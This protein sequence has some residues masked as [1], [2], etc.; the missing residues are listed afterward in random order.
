M[1]SACF[2]GFSGHRPT[3][4]LVDT[5]DVQ[6]PG[7]GRTSQ[8][9][10]L[11]AGPRVP[12]ALP[13]GQEAPPPSS[14]PLR[15]LTLEINEEAAPGSSWKILEVSFDSLFPCSSPQAPSSCPLGSNSK[16][17]VTSLPVYAPSHCHVTSSP[18]C[19]LHTDCSLWGPT[20]SD[21]TNLG[22]LFSDQL[23]PLPL[24]C[25]LPPLS[26]TLRPGPA[27]AQPGCSA[28]RLPRPS[29]PRLS[30]L[31]PHHPVS[32]VPHVLQPAAA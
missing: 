31:L 17:N 26:H 27:L 23:S 25:L 6:P 13:R 10:R 20:S 2:A 5:Q 19:N 32:F 28:W 30:H 16:I 4:L 18:E 22:S 14:Q 21:P 7:A 11:L 24:L 1:E 15:A 3:L 29:H 8:E 9:R 12:C